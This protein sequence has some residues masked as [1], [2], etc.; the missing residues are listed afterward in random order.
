MN[1]KNRFVVLDHVTFSY[2]SNK[3][4]DQLQL[5]LDR[6]TSYALI[7]KSG[8]GTSTLLNLIA[9]F[10]KPMEGT[11]TIDQREVS[12]PRKNTA[13]LFQ[14][15]G[16]FPWQT[17][18]QAVAMPL[19]L[20]KKLEKANRSTEVEE[21]LKGMNLYALKDKYPKELSG[22]EKQR[23]A[24]ARTLIGRPDLILMDEPTSALDAMTKEAIQL[25]IREYQ[26]KLKATMLFITHDIEEAV[27]LGEKIVLLN[28]DGTVTLLDNPFYSSTNVKE[29]LGFYELC[30]HIRKLMKLET[31]ANEDTE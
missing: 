8:I 14:E 5:E 11:I 28:S 6:G 19:Q 12:E 13:F 17:V 18:L 29:Q 20:E 25:L 16:L 10:I 26:K 4:L 7:G 27:S 1:T 31:K 30:I 15:L 22:G 9:G 2:G 23:V 21:L 3:I 24:L